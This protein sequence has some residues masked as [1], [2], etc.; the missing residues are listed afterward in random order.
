MLGITFL[1]LVADSLLK[2]DELCLSD[3]TDGLYHSSF[4]KL[5]EEFIDD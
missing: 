3:V 5:I 1:V 4:E 2:R